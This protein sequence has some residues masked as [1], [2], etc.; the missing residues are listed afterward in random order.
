MAS[1]AG[2]GNRLGV[3]GRCAQNTRSC[4]RCKPRSRK[5]ANPSKNHLFKQLKT[6]TLPVV[7][8]CSSVGRARASQARGRGFEPRRPLHLRPLHLRP[9]HFPLPPYPV[10]DRFSTRD[11]FEGAE[12]AN[13]KGREI[14]PLRHF[15]DTFGSAAGPVS[16][17]PRHVS[18]SREQDA[19]DN[20][21]RRGYR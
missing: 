14:P 19:R 7:C 21:R 1:K 4:Q 18:R 9:L 11:Q 2:Q 10:H 3:R 13:E 17:R 15:H 16:R 20:R 6:D 5:S 8:G 12:V